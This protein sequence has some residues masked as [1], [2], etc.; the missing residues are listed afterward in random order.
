MGSWGGI[1]GASGGGR[2]RTPGD[3]S[4]STNVTKGGEATLPGPI[5]GATLPPANPFSKNQI[6]H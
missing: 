4:G 3:L 6:K 5:A 1:A 2:G